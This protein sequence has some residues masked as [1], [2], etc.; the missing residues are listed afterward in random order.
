MEATTGKILIFIAEND[1]VLQMTLS[2]ALKDGGYE[3]EVASGGE[4][5]IQRL[6]AQGPAT[7]PSSLILISMAS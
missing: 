1:G 5:A 4:E 3:V 6:E 2:D 7:A